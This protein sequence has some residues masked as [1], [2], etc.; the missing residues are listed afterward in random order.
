MESSLN[1]N[2][3]A[4]FAPMATSTPIVEVDAPPKKTT[5]MPFPSFSFMSKSSSS[6]EQPFNFLSPTTTSAPAWPPAAAAADASA[7]EEEVPYE[8][9]KVEQVDVGEE[10]ARHSVKCKV[11]Y[12]DAGEMKTKGVGMAHIKELANKQKC[13]LLVRAST[14]LGTVL[15]NVQLN[16]SEN[17]V[18]VKDD[19][20]FSAVQFTAPANPP[21][22]EANPTRPYCFTLKVKNNENRDELIRIIKELTSDDAESDATSI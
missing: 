13:Q 14:Q 20:K 16:A 18:A 21:I 19:P 8:P 1:A 15:L 4:N 17:C 5:A 7:A 3:T 10:D 6:S 9:P 22:D 11:F 2:L 12:L